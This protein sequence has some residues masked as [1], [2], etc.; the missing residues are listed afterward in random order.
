MP[1]GRLLLDGYSWS[2]LVL[3]HQNSGRGHLQFTLVGVP[4]SRSLGLGNL[5]NRK[6]SL[7][8]SLQKLTLTTLI[9][10]TSGL[11]SPRITLEW[12]MRK[13]FH[14]P[15]VFHHASICFSP[16]IRPRPLGGHPPSP[17]QEAVC[18]LIISARVGYTQSLLLSCRL[19][20]GSPFASAQYGD[21]LECH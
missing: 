9:Q 2:I 12:R 11:A 8:S 1:A 15:S 4:M 3:T 19:S 17:M 10:S 6:Q 7:L 21:H 5:A 14:L 16:P 20:P 18:S 13:T